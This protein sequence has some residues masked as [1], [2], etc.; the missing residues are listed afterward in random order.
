MATSDSASKIFEC[1]VCLD[2][3]K[4]PVILN[5]CGH[6]LCK[7][8]LDKL[9][10]SGQWHNVVCPQ[11]RAVSRSNYGLSNVPT[12]YCSIFILGLFTPGFRIN[13]SL[14]E[15]CQLMRRDREQPESDKDLTSDCTCPHVQFVAQND[16]ENCSHCNSEFCKHCIINHK[17]ILNFESEI[18][19]GHVCFKI[20]VFPLISKHGFV[21]FLVKSLIYD[22]KIYQPIKN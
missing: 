4:D 11:C 9:R 16:L 5:G 13:Y 2:I 8:C 15:V 3:F 19:S 20:L 17:M 22:L 14:K 18:I 21:F 12:F 10:N 6:S 7:P 1:P